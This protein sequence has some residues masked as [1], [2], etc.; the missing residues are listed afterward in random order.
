MKWVAG[1]VAQLVRKILREHFGLSDV[2]EV[3]PAYKLFSSFI[4]F[5][6]NVSVLVG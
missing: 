1:E 5:R 6:R 2:G 3:L 4:D